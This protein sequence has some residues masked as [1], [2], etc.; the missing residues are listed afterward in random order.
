M[1]DLTIS[2]IQTDL[3]WEDKPANLQMLEKKISA[4][5]DKTEIIILPEMFST[6]FSMRAADLA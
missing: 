3:F 5:E 1:S 2:L 6:G 4:L